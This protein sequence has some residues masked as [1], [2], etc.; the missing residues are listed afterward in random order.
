LFAGLVVVKAPVTA[1]V[2]PVIK[3]ERQGQGGRSAWHCGIVYG[4]R[5]EIEELMAG[6]AG[7]RGAMIGTMWSVAGVGA[8]TG[9][10]AGGGA[11]GVVGC[12]GGWGRPG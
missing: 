3:Y 2:Q 1:A 10:A 8:V 7:G 11:G 5:L 6:H 4:A 9:G 12:S